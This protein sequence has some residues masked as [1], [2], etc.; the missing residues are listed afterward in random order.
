MADKLKVTQLFKFNIGGQR[1]EVSQSLLDKFP[2]SVL[3]RS[4]SDQW[5]EEPETEIFIERDGMRFRH[6]LDFVRDGKLILPVTESKDMM[7]LEL[8][9][10]GIDVEAEKID[11]ADATN[12]STSSMTLINE[13]LHILGEK[14][15]DCQ[16]AKVAMDCIGLWCTSDT[17]MVNG[18]SRIS[19]NAI[20][21]P[22]IH[23]NSKDQLILMTNSLQAFL[24]Y[25]PRRDDET[26]T[27][28]ESGCES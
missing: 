8:A 10:Y 17:F 4:A 5:K 7:T 26:R 6:V 16:S 11:D 15:S 24:K 28:S 12:K 9:Y 13:M 2:T 21:N 18:P 25:A 23:L 3:A 1:Y 27:R 19:F 20:Q 14:I 22:R